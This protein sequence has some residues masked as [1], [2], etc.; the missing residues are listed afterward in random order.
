MTALLALH[1]VA[2]LVLAAA[3][4][5]ALGTTIL[6]RRARSP[7]RVLRLLGL[8]NLLAAKT[9]VPASVAVLLTGAWLTHAAGA[10]PA[11]PWMAATLALFAISALVGVLFLVPEERRATTEARRLV[12]AGSTAI[13]DELHAHTGAPAI[14][15]AEWGAQVLMLAMFWLMLAKPA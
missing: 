6:A 1:I 10:E 14:V 2:T 9:L 7:R 15:A 13:S 11:A 12:A 4:V 3:N 5:G 8:H